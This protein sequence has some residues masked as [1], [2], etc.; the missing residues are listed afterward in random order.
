MD[1][2]S[3]AKVVGEQFHRQISVLNQWLSKAA[4][5]T[6]KFR[7]ERRRE[8]RFLAA[9]A[10]TFACLEQFDR[11]E[12]GEGRLVDRSK[13]GMRFWT[14]ADLTPG[15]AISIWDDRRGEYEGR[16]I[17]SKPAEDGFLVGVRATLRSATDAA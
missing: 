4:A 1:A 3:P 10:V 14:A 16:V 13:S 11:Y 8:R 7:V 6:R 2:G 9:G 17:W 12:T 5:K 15:A